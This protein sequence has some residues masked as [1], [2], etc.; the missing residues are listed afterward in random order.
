MSFWAP[1][2]HLEGYSLPPGARIPVFVV[3]LLE[4]G[5]DAGVELY[6]RDQAFLQDPALAKNW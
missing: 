4:H 6:R 3:A 5:A 2:T 1:W